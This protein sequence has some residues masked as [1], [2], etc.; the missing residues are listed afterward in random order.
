MCQCMIELIR[1][2]YR[3]YPNATDGRLADFLIA[4]GV[5][6]PVKCKDCKYF[7]QPHN[8]DIFGRCKN[9]R[10]HITRAGEFLPAENDFCSYGERRSNAGL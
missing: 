2:C 9:W 1:Q 7:I 10:L 3:K 6:M 5:T 4:N 8:Y